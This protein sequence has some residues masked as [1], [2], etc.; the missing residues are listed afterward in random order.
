M[1][2]SKHVWL[3]ETWHATYLL[4]CRCVST[5]YLFH[6]HE[7]LIN[8]SDVFLH[9]SYIVL[10]DCQF[11]SFCTPESLHYSPIFIPY[12]LFNNVFDSFDLIKSVIKSYDLPYQL[13]SL[14]NHILM[15]GSVDGV[16]SIPESFFD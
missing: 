3:L 11:H 6:C 15:D 8:P 5:S 16:E 10:Q 13:S 9:F 7:N 14:W 12:V 2:E 4:R 1:E